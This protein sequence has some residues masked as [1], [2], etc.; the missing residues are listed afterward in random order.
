MKI[1][2][3]GL[4]DVS[5]ACRDYI[6]ANRAMFNISEIARICGWHSSSMFKWLNNERAV[7][8]LVIMPLLDLCIKKGVDLDYETKQKLEVLQIASLLNSMISKKY[9][10]EQKKIICVGLNAKISSM[11]GDMKMAIIKLL[12][13]SAVDLILEHLSHHFVFTPEYQAKSNHH[14]QIVDIFFQRIN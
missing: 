10:L 13:D 1:K 8:E 4:V 6:N 3:K 14:E 2:Y 5:N 9:S 12:S 7:P 11:S